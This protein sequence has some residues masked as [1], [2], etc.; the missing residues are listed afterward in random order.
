MI[1]YIL[2]SFSMLL[3]SQVQ[4]LEGKLALQ[5]QRHADQATHIAEL[6]ADVAKGE[7]FKAKT[8]ERELKLKAA[9]D[10]L[11]R[12]L[13]EAQELASAK[14]QQLDELTVQVN[15]LAIVVKDLIDL[16]MVATARSQAARG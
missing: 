15:L 8:K 1:D 10:K 2:H 6:E 9:Y 7:D 5:E 4:D 16:L 13:T 12:S 14:Q 3:C 11:K